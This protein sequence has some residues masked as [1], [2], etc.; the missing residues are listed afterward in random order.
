MQFT[1]LIEWHR[2]T[3]S[4]LKNHRKNLQNLKKILRTLITCL[5]VARKFSPYSLGSPTT[6]IT[7]DDTLHCFPLHVISTCNYDFD[8]E[9]INQR[10]NKTN[11]AKVLY[12]VPRTWL[13]KKQLA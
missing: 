13:V 4:C 10:K 7:Y 11:C 6:I 1:E 2:V 5:I 9:Y 3:E 8:D 12:F